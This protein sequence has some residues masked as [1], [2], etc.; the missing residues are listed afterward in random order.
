MKCET[1]Q[2]DIGHPAMFPVE[3]PIRCIKMLSYIGATVLDPFFGSGSTGVACK[4]LKRNYIG[5]DISEKYCEI[6]KNR[7]DNMEII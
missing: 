5:I 7:I 2:K 3:L 1:N 4:M 6:A